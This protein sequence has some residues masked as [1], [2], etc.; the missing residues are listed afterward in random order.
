[1][2]KIC[3]TGAHGHIGQKLDKALR[4]AEYKVIPVPRQLFYNLQAIFEFFDFNQP[5]YII[6][7]AAFG[8]R[9]DQDN[10]FENIYANIIV[11]TNLLEMTRS[12]KYKAFINF[13]TSSVAL[14][15]QT[16]YSA[17]K[18]AGEYIVKAFVN[19][20]DKPVF[21]VRP[22]TVI[23]V[24]EAPT[25]LIPTLIRSALTQEEMPFVKEPVHDFI[26]VDDLC[27][28]IILLMEKADKLKGQS[29]DIGTG[30]GT[31]NQ[32]IKEIVEKATGNKINIKKVKY[33]RPYDTKNWVAN[34]FILDYLN[35]KPKQTL[36]QIIQDMVNAMKAGLR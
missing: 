5:D 34:P 2:I 9:F 4:K 11:L 25:H 20:F 28:A 21:S 31:T 33:L 35:W 15:Y 17:S 16:F 8:N 6:H 13:S 22:F 29:V 12:L 14:P 10:D 32:K 7:T 19:K 27:Q 23:G 24:N 18:M 26:G 36:E 3:L 1:M 30:K